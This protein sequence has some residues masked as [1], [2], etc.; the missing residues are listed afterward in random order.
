LSL[1]DVRLSGPA[2][3]VKGLDRHLAN[4][5][6]TALRVL[7]AA[8][9]ESRDHE[10]RA[11][12]LYWMAYINNNLGHFRDAS[13]QFRLA[14]ENVSKSGQQFYEL[15]RIGIETE[16]FELAERL[17]GESTT[18]VDRG[19][20][21]EPLLARLRTIQQDAPEGSKPSILST[22]GNLCSWWGGLLAQITSED[23]DV[24]SRTAALEAA[25]EAYEACGTGVWPT[26]GALE[27]NYIL[28]GVVDIEA[29]NAIEE[30]AMEELRKRSE[31][32][33]LANVHQALL[34]IKARRIM[35]APDSSDRSA[36]SAA[37]ANVQAAMAH[38]DEHVTIFSQISKYNM[39][40][41]PF[42][43]ELSKLNSQVQKSVENR[44]TRKRS[45]RAS[46][47]PSQ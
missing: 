3:L 44:P 13:E 43:D 27:A 12:A 19:V 17:E 40:R 15:E 31:P 4:D 34:L 22:I 10:L 36:F 29:Y 5:A 47:E 2:L 41:D 14:S 37:Y 25:K 45:P 18:A 20:V 23:Q 26:L 33:T 24:G 32:R 28:S 7:R 30:R 39:R 21:V 1:Q 38:V 16:F 35:V 6:R 11:L 8:S 9:Q 46:K 42:R